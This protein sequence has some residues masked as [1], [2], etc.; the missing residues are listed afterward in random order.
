[1]PFES[2]NHLKVFHT[3]LP[4]LRQ[5]PY[6]SSTASS[7]PIQFFHSFIERSKQLPGLFNDKLE[8]DASHEA[9]GG[10]KK[11]EKEEG[12][13]EGAKDEDVSGMEEAVMDEK[14]EKEEE[15][16]AVEGEGVVAREVEALVSSILQA[17]TQ[18]FEALQ[19]SNNTLQQPGNNTL[20]QLGNNTN[21]KVFSVTLHSSFTA[22]HCF[23]V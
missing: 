21:N 9:D 7:T 3:I 2:D 12:T 20:Q 6:N 16:E 23:I 13:Q 5:H 10:E 4:Q 1:M 15:E 18:V 17:L 11:E 22:F 8:T 19:Q 14:M